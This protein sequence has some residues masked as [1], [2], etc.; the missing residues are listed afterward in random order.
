MDT[1]TITRRD[2]IRLLGAGSLAGAVAMG[3]GAGGDA[4]ASTEAPE[5]IITDPTLSAVGTVAATSPEKLSVTTR[6]GSFSARPL[7]EARMYSGVSGRVSSASDFIVGDRVLVQG[8]GK[9]GDAILAGRIGSV[10]LPTEFT[11]QSID[12][13]GAYAETSI[14]AL[15]LRGSLPDR[16]RIEHS[17]QA[18]QTLRGLTWTDPRNGQTYLVL[19]EH[20]RTA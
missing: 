15:D 20:D 18:N 10:Y 6:S 17:L 12:S 13:T 4:N 11:V 19:A 7:P 2:A 16:G 3:L 9:D 8:V 14:G 1:P 5:T